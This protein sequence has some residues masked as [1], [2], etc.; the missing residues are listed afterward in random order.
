M[1]KDR[2]LSMNHRIHMYTRRKLTLH[3]CNMTLIHFH[4]SLRSHLGNINFY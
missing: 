2:G 4:A 3:L 1:L